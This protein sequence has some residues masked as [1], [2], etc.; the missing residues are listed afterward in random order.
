MCCYSDA[1]PHSKKEEELVFENWTTEAPGKKTL[2]CVYSLRTLAGE[3]LGMVLAGLQTRCDGVGTVILVETRSGPCHQND[4][5]AGRAECLVPFCEM[6]LTWA[7]N[8][9]FCRPQPSS[10][11]VTTFNLFDRFLAR[12]H[13]G[14]AAQSKDCSR[15]HR[16]SRSYCST[17]A[18]RWRCFAADSRSGKPPGWRRPP[19]A[20]SR[21]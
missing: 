12:R 4:H 6:T 2:F 8:V 7:A 3:N 10:C 20:Q 13:H 19:V 9:F 1:D 21:E 17:R 5:A 15:L 11:W 18:G 14:G 16:R